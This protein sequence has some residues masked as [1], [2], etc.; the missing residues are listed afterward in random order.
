MNHFLTLGKGAR[1][2]GGVALGAAECICGQG[3]GN[4]SG[5]RDEGAG[6]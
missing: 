5:E 2:V 1:V 6:R 4:V 3:E